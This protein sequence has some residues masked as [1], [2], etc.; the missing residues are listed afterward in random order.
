MFF[1]NVELSDDDV[2]GEV[3]E[4]WT[5]T[6]TMFVVERRWGRSDVNEADHPVRQIAPGLRTLVEDLGLQGRADV[7]QL[8]ARSL[9]NDVVQAELGLR[10]REL[11]MVKG[12][13]PSS[14]ASYIKLAMGT[15]G[16]IRAKIRLQIAGPTGVAWAEEDHSEGPTIAS[17]YLYS[18]VMAIAGGTH[19]MMCN[20]IG[21]RL[22]ELPREPSFDRDKPFSEVVRRAA[23]WS[24]GS[25]PAMST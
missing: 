20:V 15:F 24:S 23:E 16:P 12:A 6:Q 1:D 14:I 11:S 9:V 7:R 25:A 13:D 4:G 3:D 18:R 21:E 5:V 10:V 17:E 19:Q 22:L 2:V 8:V